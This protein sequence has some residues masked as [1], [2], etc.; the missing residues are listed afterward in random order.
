M[1]ESPAGTESGEHALPANGRAWRWVVAAIVLPVMLLFTQ[2]ILASRAELDAAKTEL[3]ILRERVTAIEANRFTASDAREV[4]RDQR[5]EVD[6]RL[7]GL[8][9]V[10]TG[11]LAEVRRRIEGLEG[12]R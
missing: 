3:S 12:R 11:E 9:A 1:T 8:R 4:E 5:R 7:D 6:R 10:L 2:Q